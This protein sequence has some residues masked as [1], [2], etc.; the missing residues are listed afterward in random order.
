MFS[1][2]DIKRERLSNYGCLF[3]LGQVSYLD[4][5]CQLLKL[6]SGKVMVVFG[7]LMVN[8][9]D[10][11]APAVRLQNRAYPFRGTRLLSY[12]ILVMDAP[13][14][15]ALLDELLIAEGELLTNQTTQAG[16]TLIE[17]LS[18]R[19]LEI[20]ALIAEDRSNREIADQ[21]F[22]TVGTVKWYL[23]GIYGKLGV[24]NRTL[25]ILRAHQLNL[26]P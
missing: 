8:L 24:Q 7:K 20:L 14:T 5:G 22:L 10:R 12:L 21:L 3:S 6:A 11:V 1:Y 25:A 26:L 17:P 2:R 15:T 19:E 18:E 9:D 4:Q 13:V 16:E 23:T